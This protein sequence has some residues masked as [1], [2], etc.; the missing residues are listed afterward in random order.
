MKAFKIIVTETTEYVVQAETSDQAESI[1]CSAWS[2][3]T[4][5]CSETIIR[6]N[7]DIEFEQVIQCRN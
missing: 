7:T 6:G 3:G 2:D 4:I 5:N 1:I